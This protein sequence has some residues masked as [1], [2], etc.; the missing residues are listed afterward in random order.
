MVVPEERIK[1]AMVMAALGQQDLV[2]ALDEL[3]GRPWDAELE[4][5]RYAGEGAPVRWLH[6]VVSTPTSLT[7]CSLP[8][9]PA[10][11]RARGEGGVR[12]RIPAAAQEAVAY[13]LVKAM[14]TL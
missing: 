7:H 2:E 9:A 5:F 3:L 4:P 10:A 1:H 14:A 8:H 11:P 13:R 12:Q 6:K